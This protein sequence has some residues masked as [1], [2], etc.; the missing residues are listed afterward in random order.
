MNVNLRKFPLIPYKTTQ[1]GIG[2]NFQKFLSI[3]FARHNTD[4]FWKCQKWAQ[5]N[6][7]PFLDFLSWCAVLCSGGYSVFSWLQFYKL[8]VVQGIFE[9]AQKTSNKAKLC[10]PQ[11]NTPLIIALAGKTVAT[12]IEIPIN[13]SGF[14]STHLFFPHVPFI[15][16]QNIIIDKIIK[17]IAAKNAT[18][19][20]VI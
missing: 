1:A 9:N 6:R 5:K 17:L 7:K 15:A 12:I 10:C 16:T 20:N 14:I 19:I 2:G 13:K 4:D 8:E 11:S 18:Q 3:P